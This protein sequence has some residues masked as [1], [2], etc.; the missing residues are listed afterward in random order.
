MP[1]RKSSDERKRAAKAARRES[2]KPLTPAPASAH[3]FKQLPVATRPE[4]RALHRHIGGAKGLRAILQDFY[5]RMER[6]A[7]IGFFFHGKDVPRIAERQREFLSRA[8]GARKS[9]RGKPPARAHEKLPPIL[10][11]FFDRRLRLLEETLRDHE[12]SEE[13][14]RTWIGFENAFR[15]GIVSR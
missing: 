14:I 12:V 6:D 10:P 11:G 1:A 13:D 3:P 9:Y 4:L 5:A 2:P 15:E 7:M 8:M